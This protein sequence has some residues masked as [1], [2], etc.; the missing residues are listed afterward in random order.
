MDN[1]NENL[2]EQSDRFEEALKECLS[3]IVFGTSPRSLITSSMCI[4]ALEHGGSLRQLI[5]HGAPSSALALFRC[6]FEI[7]V[8]ATWT[9]FAAEDDWLCKFTAPIHTLDEPVRS[10][11]MDE[12]LKSIAQKAP[13]KANELL[14]GLKAAAWKPLHSYVHGGVRPIAENLIG[15]KPEFI[16]N[17]ILNSNGLTAMAALVMA[18]LVPDKTHARRVVEIQYKYLDCLPPTS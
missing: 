14:N 18:D 1:S 8:R 3:Q 10:P 7:V 13:R 16:R 11:S 4:L 6:Q 9:T 2:L 12:M 15:Y 5:R 17:T